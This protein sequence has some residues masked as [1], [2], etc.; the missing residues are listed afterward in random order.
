MKS[1]YIF[2]PV[3]SRRLGKSLG[4]NLVPYKTCPFDCIYCE[5]GKTNNLTLER[6][7]YVTT[8]K[9][10]EALD[11]YLKHKPELDYI[12]FAGSGE[13]TLHNNISQIIKFIKNNYHEYKVA[14]ITNGIFFKDKKI[15]EEV[16]KVDLIIPSLDAVTQK[17]FKKINRPLA[18][19]KADDITKGLENLRKGYKG[20]LWLEIFIIPGINDIEE[21]LYLFLD[22]INKINPEKVQINSTDRPGTENW[23]K[24]LER[25]QV[26]KII[27]YLKNN[28]SIDIEIL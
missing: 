28:T 13:P 17:V 26:V 5:C 16:S 15:V 27:K 6:K 10:I 24:G 14:L 4:I 22:I 8:D 25:E 9:V 21:E 18:G 20:E 1:K 3:L 11:G 2:G 19:I 12:T 7:E 23:V